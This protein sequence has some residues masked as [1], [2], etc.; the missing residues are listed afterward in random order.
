MDYVIGLLEKTFSGSELI[1]LVDRATSRINWHYEKSPVTCY[2][3]SPAP[4]SIKIE[5]TAFELRFG[6]R[7]RINGCAFITNPQIKPNGEYPILKLI[8]DDSFPRY[9][10]QKELEIFARELYAVIRGI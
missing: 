1:A 4:D 9:P 6:P 10:S 8:A 5:D 7:K 3:T 2:V